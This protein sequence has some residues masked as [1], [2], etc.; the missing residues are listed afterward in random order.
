MSRSLPDRPNLDRL[1][2]EAKS[3]VKAHRAGDRDV[4]SALRHIARL[5]SLSDEQILAETVSLQ[6]AQHALARDYGFRGWTELRDHVEARRAEEAR[7]DEEFDRAMRDESVKVRM[8]ALRSLAVR[9]HPNWSAPV[10]FG[11][12]LAGCAPAVPSSAARLLGPLARDRSWRIRREAV[13]ALAAYVHHR[14]PK[15]SAGLEAALQD[16]SH[17]V[18]HAAARALEVRCPGC[19]DRK[20]KSHD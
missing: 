6:E 16:R 4:C 8:A 18:R 7:A 17:A 12:A 14:D 2:R 15:L 9:I 13:C 5:S 11:W 20:R 19:G 10:A 1:R 3:V